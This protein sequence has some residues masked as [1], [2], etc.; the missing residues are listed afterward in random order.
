MTLP[1]SSPLVLEIHELVAGYGDSTIVR[2]VSLTVA[3]GE[4]VTVLGPNGSGKSTL[5]K[6]VVGLARVRSGQVLLWGRDITQIRP[7]RAATAGI[8]YLPQVRGVFPGLTVRENL[9][10]AL[11]RGEPAAARRRRVDEAVAVFPSLRDHLDRR[12][13]ALSG[14]ERQMV[15]MARA[16]AMRLRCLLLDEPSAAVAPLVADEIFAQI[17]SM[18]AHGAS[19]LL[20]E[21]NARK[22]LAISD[23]G[24]VLDGGAA[25]FTGD[26]RELLASEEVGRLYL[27]GHVAPHP[28]GGDG[29]DGSPDGSDRYGV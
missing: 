16:I 12:A 23:R 3:Q 18:R 26:G 19:V 1:T 25:A 10:L 28:T 4:I 17:G 15:G 13:G 5:L 20:V 21:Q 6:A 27:G 2:G 9:T 22:A 14:G 29:E 11:P 24:Y 7:E 8:A